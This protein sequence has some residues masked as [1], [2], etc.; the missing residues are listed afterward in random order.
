METDRSFGISKLISVQSRTV[1]SVDQ[2]NSNCWM[3]AQAKSQPQPQP[4]TS[5]DHPLMHK[6][7]KAASQITERLQ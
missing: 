4:F 5:K 1:F 2:S 3:L 7:G 6:I